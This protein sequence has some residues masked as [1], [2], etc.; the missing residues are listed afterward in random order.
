MKELQE[1]LD[2]NDRIEDINEKIYGLRVAILSPKNQVITGMPRGGK[3]ENVVEKYM[4]KVEELKNDRQQL[5]QYIKKQ[6]NEALKK[7]PDA[8]EQEIELLRLRCVVGHKWDECNEIMND[9]YGNW[10]L[11]KV[12]RIYRKFNIRP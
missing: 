4:I 5:Y 8:T 10:N 11:N 6:W 9:T 1:C 12:F 7:M 3:S 2:T